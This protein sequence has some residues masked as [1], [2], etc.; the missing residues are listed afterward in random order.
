MKEKMG[1]REM[2]YFVCMQMYN[3]SQHST[4]SPFSLPLEGLFVLL[5]HQQAAEGIHIRSNFDC[6]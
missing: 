6:D 5:I 2:K 4:F 1:E 3:S